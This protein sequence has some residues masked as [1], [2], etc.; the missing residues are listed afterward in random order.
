MAITI[1]GTSNWRGERP[2][3]IQ[4]TDRRQHVYVIGKTG[5]GKTTLLENMIVQDIEA[6]RGAAVLGGFRVTATRRGRKRGVGLG[7][8]RSPGLEGGPPNGRSEVKP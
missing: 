7:L 4:P 1:L 5:M 6:G 8:S 2:F 3:G